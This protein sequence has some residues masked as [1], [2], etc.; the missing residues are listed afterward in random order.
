MRPF[1]KLTGV[2]KAFPGVRA[3]DAVDLDIYPGEIHGLIG[4]NGAGKSTLIKILTGVHKSDRGTIYIEGRGVALEGPRDAMRYGI[5]AIYQELNI[6][7]QLSV[8]ENVFLGRE[9]KNGKGNKGLLNIKK[10]R[11]KAGELLGELGQHMDTGMNVSRLG[12]G[13]QQMVEI[14]RA[15]CIK[16]RLLIMDEPT[17]S[18]TAREAKALFKSVRELKKKGIAIIF[19]SHRLEEV[20]E[21]C[22]R[23]TV[24]R[25]GRKIKTL[26]AGEAGVGELITLMVGRSLEQQFPKIEIEAGE[27]ALRVKNLTRRGV[28]KDI[29]F[30]AR[31]GEVVGFAGLVGAGRT[32][33][34]RAVFGADPYD[35]GE[36]FVNGVQ[37]QIRTPG[38]AMRHGLAFLTEDRKGQGLILD[39]T[40]DFNVNLPAYD[41][42][43]PGIFLNLKKL[44]QVTKENIKRLNI[45]PPAGSFAVRQLSGGNQQKV[46]IAKW[47]NTGGEI[48]IFDEP[49]R[50]IDVG[51]KVEVYNVLNGLIRQGAAVIMVSSELPEIL[52][53]SDRIYV[54]HEG[55]LM[56]EIG[57]QEATQENIMS[58]ATGGGI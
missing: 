42:N 22:D 34:M 11:E 40:I 58:A 17:S 18:L 46:V 43:S 23:V 32:E 41:K 33:V 1:I 7:K 36:I 45:N 38:E 25:D 54:M 37:V 27:E 30:Y 29:S 19:I 3:L 35:S 39:G 21:L 53:M 13:Q 10:M 5:T 4:E 16:T 52:G 50:G 55:R 6:I 24:M 2:S 49:T 28:F 14:A 31:K 12:I 56:A 9:L 15:M 44:K 26:P 47:L 57:R 51:A 48:F 8:A 20:K